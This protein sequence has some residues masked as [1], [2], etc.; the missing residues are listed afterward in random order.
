MSF[1][2]LL[3]EIIINIKDEKK[4]EA[5]N[6]LASLYSLIPKF[7][8]QITIDDGEQNVKLAKSYLINAYS[9]LDEENWAEIENNISK[10]NTVFKD[11]TN[12]IEYV[13]NREFKVNRTYVLI[14]ELQN[15]LVYKDKKLFL[16]KYVNVIESINTL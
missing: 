12:N 3:N 13:K 11:I 5:I 4:E 8:K 1:S 14:K 6:N 2:N 16:V 7:E 9:L 10:L 15:S